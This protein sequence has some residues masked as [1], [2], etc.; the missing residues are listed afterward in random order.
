MV[1]PTAKARCKDSKGG[2]S[3]NQPQSEASSSTSSTVKKSGYRRKPTCKLRQPWLS[4]QYLPLIEATLL[5]GPSVEA[6]SNVMSTRCASRQA[7]KRRQLIRAAKRRDRPDNVSTSN[8][9]HVAGPIYVTEPILYEQVTPM[10]HRQ[11]VSER[12]PAAAAAYNMKQMQP[13]L[14]TNFAPE[15]ITPESCRKKDDAKKARVLRVRKKVCKLQLERNKD[16]ASTSGTRRR[17]HSRRHPVSSWDLVTC[18]DC[19]AYV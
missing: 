15:A 4:S 6:D 3:D 1:K 10:I 2:V 19:H 8:P 18:P 7:R 16:V 12:R 5:P 14:T 11:T 17:G 13:C 9:T